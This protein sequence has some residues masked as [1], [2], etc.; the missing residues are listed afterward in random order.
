MP[1]ISIGALQMRVSSFQLKSLP[2]SLSAPCGNVRR[3]TPAQAERAE[4]RWRLSSPF[5]RKR[6]S[7]YHNNDRFAELLC[8]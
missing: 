5:R 1:M 3:A 2:C 4:V 7:P 8:N 6:L